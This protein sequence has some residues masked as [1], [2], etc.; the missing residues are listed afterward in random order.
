MFFVSL[1][2]L[3]F[4]WLI[5][6]KTLSIKDK[7]VANNDF[8]TFVN[9]Y[10]FFFLLTFSAISVLSFFAPLF[11]LVYQEQLNNLH[12]LFLQYFLQKFNFLN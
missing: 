12:N 6:I 8:Y 9:F 2:A 10:I 4:T 3:Q 5:T 1:L 7:N 11:N